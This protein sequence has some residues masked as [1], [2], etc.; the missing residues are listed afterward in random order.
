MTRSRMCIFVVLST[1]T[2][3]CRSYDR[4]DTDTVG[5]AAPA[6]S[7]GER[8][9]IDSLHEELHS[10]QQ[11]ESE[12]GALVESLRHSEDRQAE[13]LAMLGDR[14]AQSSVLIQC[15]QSIDTA[16]D[17]TLENIRHAQ[18]HGYKQV[19]AEFMGE[20]VVEVRRRFT[21]GRLQHTDS[22]LDLAIQGPGFFSVELPN[23]DI[24]YTRYGHFFLDHTG[25]MKI[26]P[27]YPLVDLSGLPVGLSPIA[28][29][30]EGTVSAIAS[31]GTTVNLGQIKLVVFPHPEGLRLVDHVLFEESEISGEAQ[32]VVPGEHGTGILKQGYLE[33]SN[34]DLTEELHTLHTLQAWRSG[35]KRAI[36]SLHKPDL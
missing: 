19:R 15:L 20:S 22:P 34:V 36:L 9:V 2:V 13:L 25:E 16:I 32:L 6:E 11:F 26:M 14:M 27:G 5:Q 23:G 24:R 30:Q 1:M 35:L 21:Q 3:G 18:T 4:H 7:V 29:G 33:N 17:L 8:L 12:L 10:S 31:Q 28:V